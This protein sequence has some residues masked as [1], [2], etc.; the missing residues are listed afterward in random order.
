M[1][2]NELNKSELQE[3]TKIYIEE[4][5]ICPWLCTLEEFAER[6]VRKCE[7]CEEFVLVEDYDLPIVTNFRGEKYHVC[8]ECLKEEW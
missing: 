7:C 2:L 3:V 4:R 1:K 8:D 5:D 6:F